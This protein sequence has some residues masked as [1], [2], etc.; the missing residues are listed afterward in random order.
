[1]TD[2]LESIERVRHARRLSQKAIADALG[3]TQG[4]Y[5]KA[6]RGL[7]PLSVKLEVQIQAWIERNG[8]MPGEDDRVA[9]RMGELAAS[10]QAQCMELMHLTGLAAAASMSHVDRDEPA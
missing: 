8:R 4:H 7:V 5:S 1:M 9:R 6:V 2:V 10:I 3:V